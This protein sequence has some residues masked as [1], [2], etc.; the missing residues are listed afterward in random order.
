MKDTQTNI[1]KIPFMRYYRSLMTKRGGRLKKGAASL[2]RDTIMDE[3]GISQRTFYHWLRYP[4]TVSKA[5]RKI[6]EKAAKTE[7]DFV[8]FVVR[9][10]K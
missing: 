8:K 4:E 2:F 10:G 9:N 1:R 6:I 3:C 5:N 7:I